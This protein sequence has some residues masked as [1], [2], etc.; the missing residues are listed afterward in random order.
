MSLASTVLRS[1]T[2][3]WSGVTCAVTVIDSLIAPVWSVASTLALAAASSRTPVLIHFLNPW[4]ST[5]MS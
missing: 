3:V 4:S 2:S 5:A 1:A